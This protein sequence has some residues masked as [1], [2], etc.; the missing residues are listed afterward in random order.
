MSQIHY[1]LLCKS[2]YRQNIISKYKFKVLDIKYKMVFY[3]IGLGLG[4]ERDITIK[5]LDA[6]KSSFKVFLEAYTSI[7]GVDK[8]KLE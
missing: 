4:D 6:I 7:L 1:V 8:S 3:I 2:N 5:G